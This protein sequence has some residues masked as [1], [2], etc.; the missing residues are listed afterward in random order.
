MSSLTRELFDTYPGHKLIQGLAEG[1]V[2]DV[3]GKK[4]TLQRANDEQLYIEGNNV[5]IS[6]GLEAVEV[7]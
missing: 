1:K 3:K 2:F 7:S 4:V 6:L 5:Q